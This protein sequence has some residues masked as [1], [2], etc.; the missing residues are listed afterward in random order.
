MASALFP[1][2]SEGEDCRLSHLQNPDLLTDISSQSAANGH[3]EGKLG[4]HLVFESEE[5]TYSF[6]EPPPLYTFWQA[7]VYLEIS[8][9]HKGS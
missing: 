2:L 3:F 1:T 7:V 6:P 5:V 8:S 4:D 9:A